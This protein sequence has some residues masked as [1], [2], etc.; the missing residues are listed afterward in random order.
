SRGEGP[1]PIRGSPSRVE[2]GAGGRAAAGTGQELP[3][4]LAQGRSRSRAAAGGEGRVAVA[5]EPGPR[6]P[7]RGGMMHGTAPS[8]CAQQVGSPT[9]TQ[10]IHIVDSVLYTFGP[11]KGATWLKIRDRAL[12]LWRA[13]GLEFRLD[14]DPVPD[15]W[16]GN[17]SAQYY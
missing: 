7:S 6:R 1:R 5:F 15:D 17:L 10:P 8:N 14:E 3:F 12:D 11:T 13:S 2:R 9:Y 16:N 4:Q